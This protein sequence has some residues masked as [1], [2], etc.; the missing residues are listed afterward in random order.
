M[1]SDR[2]PCFVRLWQESYIY[3]VKVKLDDDVEN[4]VCTFNIVA[5]FPF[6]YIH[7]YTYIY[8][9]LC[10][11]WD[12]SK[13]HCRW[14]KNQRLLSTRWCLSGSFS[15]SIFD[16]STSPLPVRVPFRIRTYDG[17][18]TKT[19]QE[20]KPPATES[21][22]SP[23]TGYYMLCHLS[24]SFLYQGKVYSTDRFPQTGRQ[25]SSLSKLSSATRR[26]SGLRPRFPLK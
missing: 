19:E 20:T 5:F 12:R 13:S 8:V 1:A 26:Q 17:T 18:S 6:F 23:P 25:I 7:I 16:G 3:H 15:F 2:E 22:W 21:W 11:F 24:S 10:V 9:C 4:C 14:V